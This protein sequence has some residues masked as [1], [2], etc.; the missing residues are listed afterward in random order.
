M[1]ALRFA[2]ERFIDYMTN[3]G[4]LNLH[5]YRYIDW[6]KQDHVLY[7]A[8]RNIQDE[9]ESKEKDINEFTLLVIDHLFEMTHLGFGLQN[10][11]PNHPRYMY[12][13][14][15][16]IRK[17]R[18]YRKYESYSLAS[19][20]KRYRMARRAAQ[21][22]ATVRRQPMVNVRYRSTIGVHGINQ[23]YRKAVAARGR[24]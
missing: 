12:Y 3:E 6:A 20:K 2:A 13:S 14:K 19:Y 23:M 22:N 21:H 8:V 11:P 17:V 7:L 24:H 5:E 15:T 9:I 16:C 10:A 4:F 1:K 18:Q